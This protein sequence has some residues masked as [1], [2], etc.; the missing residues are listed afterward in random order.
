MFWPLK[1]PTHNWPFFKRG[2]PPA[3]R[4]LFIV[5]SEPAIVV[6]FR[7]L[8][9][10][11]TTTFPATILLAACLP[12]KF[13]AGFSPWTFSRSKVSF[14]P[15]ANQHGP[16]CIENWRRKPVSHFLFVDLP[17]AESKWPSIVTFCLRWG[18]PY[19]SGV[20]ETISQQRQ[21]CWRDLTLRRVR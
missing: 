20:H 7:S 21:N 16:P 17:P 9:V 11:G 18:C 2:A 5:I 3:R 8:F 19:K 6:P 12:K 1:P 13:I 10:C 4:H 14:A 15:G